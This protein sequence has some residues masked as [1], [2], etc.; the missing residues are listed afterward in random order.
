MGTQFIATISKIQRTSPSDWDRKLFLDSHAV[1]ELSLI[2]CFTSRA[3]ENNSF[4][5]HFEGQLQSLGDSLS[6]RDGL[7]TLIFLQ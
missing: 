5:S 7:L 1:I 6:L 3:M 2:F 4:R